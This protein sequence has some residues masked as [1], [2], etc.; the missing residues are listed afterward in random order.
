M[1]IRMKI[2]DAPHPILL[3]KAKPVEKIDKKI[4][5]LAREM[6]KTLEAQED[7]PG[8]GLAAPQVGHSLALF[9]IKSDKKSKAKVFV[10][11]VILRKIG[12]G[13]W[14]KRPSSAKA[15]KS[16]G[17]KRKTKLEGCLSLPKIWGELKRAKKVLLQFTTLAAE[18]KKE[19]FSGFEAIII[20]HEIDHLKGILF[21]KRV[22]EQEGRLFEEKGD[23]LVRIS[24][25]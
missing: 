18:E 5:K 7:P 13:K 6:I 9:V 24:S 20:Q 1:S 8:V 23:Q 4:K 21:T 17:K 16:K 2:I 19:W 14:E 22:V 25:I 15:S 12:S 11:P 3:K 10:N